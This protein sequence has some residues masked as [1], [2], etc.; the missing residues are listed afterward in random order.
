MTVQELTTYFKDS[1]NFDKDKFYEKVRQNYAKRIS[2]DPKFLEEYPDL[3][4]KF[5][6]AD[7]CLDQLIKDAADAGIVESELKDYPDEWVSWILRL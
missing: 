1:N 7:V 2:E 4:Q 5:K 3:N 6:N